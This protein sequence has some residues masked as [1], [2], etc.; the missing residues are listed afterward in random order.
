MFSVYAAAL[1]KMEALDSQM[2]KTRNASC[3]M[4]VQEF[5]YFR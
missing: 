2:K 5:L 3:V 4:G 1:I